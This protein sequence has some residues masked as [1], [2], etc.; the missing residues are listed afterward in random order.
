MADPFHRSS[1]ESLLEWPSFSRVSHLYS[2]SPLASASSSSSHANTVSSFRMI[3]ARLIIFRQGWYCC[4]FIGR[5]H[6]ALACHRAY[7]YGGRYRR[8]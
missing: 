2:H 7:V 8:W 3:L 4:L 5:S 1:R 6:F